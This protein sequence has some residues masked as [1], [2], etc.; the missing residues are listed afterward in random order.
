MLPNLTWWVLG[1]NTAAALYMT[2]VIWLVQCVHYP[3]LRYVGAAA[4]A[5][6]HQRHVAAIFPVVALPMLV[7]GLTAAWLTLQPP[8][9]IW[10]PVLWG[11][12][13]CV[14]A[15]FGVTALVSV[16]CHDQLA[17]GFDAATLDTLIRT[18]WLRTLAWTGHGGLSLLALAQFGCRRP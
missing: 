5:D 14:L 11:G 10:P 3:L 12:L 15:A 2:G 4:F 18:N 1:L 7:E 17:Q 13:V 6:Y 8:T 16:P 9:G